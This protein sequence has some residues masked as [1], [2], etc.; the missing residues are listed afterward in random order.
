MRWLCF[1]VLIGVSACQ[2]NPSATVNRYLQSGACSARD[3]VELYERFGTLR[4]SSEGRAAEA[5]CRSEAEQRVRANV[6]D[7]V[8][9]AAVFA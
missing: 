8:S 2:T 4:P 9:T 3:Q 1:L 5:G 7:R 6:K